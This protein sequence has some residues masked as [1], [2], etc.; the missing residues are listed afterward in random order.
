MGRSRDV[1]RWFIEKKH[2]Q[3]DALRRVREIIMDADPRM[4]ETV[5][6]GTIQ[7]VYKIGLANFVQ[8]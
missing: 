6:F 8:L 3:E 1:D 7:F 2:P 5:Q 4:T